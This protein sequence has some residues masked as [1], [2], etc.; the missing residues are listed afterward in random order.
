MFLKNK[1]V[2]CC[3][4]SR[5]DTVENLV[6]VRFFFFKLVITKYLEP[7]NFNSFAGMIPTTAML[8]FFWKV[9]LTNSKAEEK[10]QNNR[11][12]SATGTYCD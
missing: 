6:S 11:G 10:A 2:D 8:N 4:Y 7:Q 9:A 1:Q 3:G 5:M 12:S